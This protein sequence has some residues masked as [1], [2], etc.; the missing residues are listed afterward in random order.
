[1][2]APLQPTDVGQQLRHRRVVAVR[3]EERQSVDGGNEKGQRAEGADGVDE[4]DTKGIER[5]K[6]SREV[7]GYAAGGRLRR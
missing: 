7:A 6:V 5:L 4:M 3:E 1:M 2:R